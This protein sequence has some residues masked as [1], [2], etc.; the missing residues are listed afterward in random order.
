MNFFQAEAPVAQ[1]YIE[2]GIWGT[3]WHRVAQA[4][5]VMNPDTEMPIHDIETEPDTHK[6]FSEP[7]WSLI[8]PQG[9]MAV[10][11]M[12]VTVFTKVRTEEEIRCVMV[13]QGSRLI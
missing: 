10:L 2:T 7:D 4:L 12:S 11:Q 9:L 6:G 5:Q 1:L 8:S 13:L 3:L